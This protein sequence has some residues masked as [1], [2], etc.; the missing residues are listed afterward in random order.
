MRLSWKAVEHQKHKQHEKRNR[1]RKKRGKGPVGH[2]RLLSEHSHTLTLSHSHTLTLSQTHTPTNSHTHIT[3]KIGTATLSVV[4]ANV[5]VC[6]FVENQGPLGIKGLTSQKTVY[7]DAFAGL[8]YHGD[9]TGPLRLTWKVVEHQKHKQHER[10][11]RSRKKRGTG[12]VGHIR[13]LSHSH[14]LT[15]SHSHTLTEK[16]KTN[17]TQTHTENL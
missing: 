14:T 5:P 15:L 16:T 11:N 4:F 3:I 17:D 7:T 1:S 9:L 13:A 8:K 10:R 6:F 2:I 12:P